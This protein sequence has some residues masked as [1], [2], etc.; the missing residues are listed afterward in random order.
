MGFAKPTAAAGS[1]FT[2]PRAFNSCLT[3]CQKARVFPEKHL[4]G[5]WY[6]IPP[7][8]LFLVNP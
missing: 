5:Y 6:Q 4:A 8:G 7:Y 2:E 1:G 3:Q